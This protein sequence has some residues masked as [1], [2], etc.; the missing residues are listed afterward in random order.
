MLISKMPLIQNR[1]DIQ[2]KLVDMLVK[3]FNC[4]LLHADDYG[5]TGILEF[6]IKLKEGAVPRR[7][8]PRPLNPVMQESLKEKIKTW[9]EQDLIEPANSPWPTGPSQEEGR[10]GLLDHRLQIIESFHR[11][12]QLPI[13]E[14][15]VQPGETERRT[16]LFHVGCFWS[17]P[18]HKNTSGFKSSHYF[19]IT[20]R[21]ISVCLSA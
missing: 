4:L 13:A 10:T 12:G 3:N 17:L 11:Q 5:E 18:Q 6:Y 8:H 2:R 1:P 16:D 21:S 15:P 14:D 9:T 19:H 7:Q 20:I